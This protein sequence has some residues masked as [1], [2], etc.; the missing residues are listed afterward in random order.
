MVVAM[1]AATAVAKAVMAAAAMGA[2]VAGVPVARVEGAKVPMAVQ[3][4]PATRMD[5]MAARAAAW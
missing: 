3:V 1:A 4:A 5:V 2:G